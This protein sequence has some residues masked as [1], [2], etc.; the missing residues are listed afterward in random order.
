MVR[1]T[2]LEHIC[3]FG[4]AGLPD[5]IAQNVLGSDAKVHTQK[6]LQRIADKFASTQAESVAASIPTGDQAD[7]K[8][9]TM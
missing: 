4:N 1:L 7:E 5:N 3:L 8:C 2:R 6:I 9:V